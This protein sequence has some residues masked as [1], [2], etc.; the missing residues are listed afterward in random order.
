VK[1]GRCGL[2]TLVIAMLAGC[3]SA[4]ARLSSHPSTTVAAPPPPSGPVYVLGDSLTVGMAP[5]LP[6]LLP[7][8]SV[9][10]DGKTG[11][12]A[13]DGLDILATRQAPLPP[14]VVMALGTNDVESPEQF[15]AVIDR[16]MALLG[17]RR[18]IWVNIA[19]PTGQPFN[20]DLDAARIRYRN[21]EV[22]DWASIM[23]ARPED[24][25]ADHIHNTGAGYRL[26]AEVV[27]WVLQKPA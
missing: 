23:A 7:G 21:L 11:R 24:L 17:P 15:T 6:S 19:S 26:R 4:A 20:R 1:L 16:T 12:T 2:C 5:Y 9:E 3:G 18:V 14:T 10:I 25:V 22:I 27:A 13:T 8:R